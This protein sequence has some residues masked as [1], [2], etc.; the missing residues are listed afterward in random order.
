MKR[1]IE[2]V[3]GLAWITAGR[4]VENYIPHSAVEALFGKR[5]TGGEDPFESFFEALETIEPGLGRKSEREKPALAERLKPHL[6]RERC[7]GVL[8]LDR[9]LK[10]LCDLIRKCNGL[11]EGPRCPIG[12][13][14]HH[15]AAW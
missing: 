15:S 2:A 1:E 11:I 14:I 4:E 12:H 7:E 5:P 8:D 6:T 13:E 9:M 3:R 10:S